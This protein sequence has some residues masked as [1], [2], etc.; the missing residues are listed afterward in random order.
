MSPLNGAARVAAPPFIAAAMARPNVVLSRESDASGD[1]NPNSFL[2]DEEAAD[3]NR[4]NALQWS[5][6]SVLNEVVSRNPDAFT[7]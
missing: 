2:S 1:H 7:H 6:S 5:K 3:I 4:I